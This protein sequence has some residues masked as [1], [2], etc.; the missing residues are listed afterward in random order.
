M[1]SRKV[2][3]ILR[4]KNMQ[5][6]L[7]KDGWPVRTTCIH[8]PL[9]VGCRRGCDPLIFRRILKN[10]VIDTSGRTWSAT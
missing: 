8:R 9:V 7:C 6:G 1:S 4:K 5:M 3:S 10:L 2:T